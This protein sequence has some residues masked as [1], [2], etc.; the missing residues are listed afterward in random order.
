MM[1]TWSFME[2][3]MSYPAVQKKAQAEIGEVVSNLVS[4]TVLIGMCLQILFVLRDCLGGKIST[5]FHMF[6][7]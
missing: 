4:W 7:A 3:M 1:T 6:V 2:A 5:I